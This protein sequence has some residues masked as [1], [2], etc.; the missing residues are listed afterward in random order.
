MPEVMNEL[1]LKQFFPVHILEC[2]IDKE[3]AKE[4]KDVIKPLIKNYQITLPEKPYKTDY[5]EPVSILRKAS[6]Q[7][8]C[9][10]QV[11]DKIIELGNVFTEAMG[12]EKRERYFSAW[13]NIFEGKDYQPMQHHCKNMFDIS[14]VYCVDGDENCSPLTI[15]NPSPFLQGTPVSSELNYSKAVIPF[16]TGR[17]YIFP[18]WLN[19]EIPVNLNNYWSTNDTLIT[20]GFQMDQSTFLG[21]KPIEE[22]STKGTGRKIGSAGQQRGEHQKPYSGNPTKGKF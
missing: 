10:E 2:D 9:I 22:D 17:V 5:G 8:K 20:M 15:H 12:L 6:E 14:G 1:T 7:S 18:S 19:H 11:T 16:K 3:L 4:F 21:F 13:I